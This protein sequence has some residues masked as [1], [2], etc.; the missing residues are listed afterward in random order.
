MRYLCFARDLHPR[1][2][3]NQQLRFLIFFVRCECHRKWLRAK[4]ILP[5]TLVNHGWLR[6]HVRRSTIDKLVDG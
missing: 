5:G 6:F 2:G 1:T 3:T 4:P